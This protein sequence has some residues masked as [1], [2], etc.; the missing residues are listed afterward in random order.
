MV[1]ETTRRPGILT[2]EAFHAAADP[3][4]FPEQIA[5]G[6]QPWQPKKFYI[7]NVCAFGSMT[8]PDAGLDGE[9]QH[10]PAQCGTGNVIHSVR[11]EGPAAPDVTGR[12]EL[13]RRSRATGSRFTGCVDSAFL[14]PKERTGHEKNFFDGIETACQALASRLDGSKKRKRPGLTIATGGN[15][16]TGL[17]KRSKEQRAMILSSAAEPYASCADL[18]KLSENNTSSLKRGHK[19][20]FA[21]ST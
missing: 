7:G 11:D 12:G 17:P 1:M 4:R 21:D 6:L 2:K 3:K 19:A 13:D 8:C 10:R 16:E 18:T 5:E 20:R 15:R 14:P 9:I